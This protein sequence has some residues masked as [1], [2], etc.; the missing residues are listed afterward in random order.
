VSDSVGAVGEIDVD[1]EERALDC[2]AASEV[3]G[4]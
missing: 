1:L 2:G 4:F 3:L